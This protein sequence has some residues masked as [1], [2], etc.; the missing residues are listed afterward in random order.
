[1][2][3]EDPWDFMLR[4]FLVSGSQLDLKNKDILCIS[5]KLWEKHPNLQVLDLSQ[6]KLGDNPIPEEFG[7]LVNLKSLRLQ[8]CGIS[9]LPKSFLKLKKLA[10]V[11]LDKN[12]FKAFFDDSITRD[13]VELD[14]L[15]YLNM[16]GN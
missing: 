8:Q 10:T 3:D 5:P 13:Q 16:N 9:S 11:D 7:N 14:S 6:N 12:N 4:E 2:E 1:M 15:T